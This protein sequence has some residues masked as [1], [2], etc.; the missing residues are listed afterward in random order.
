MDEVTLL[1][2]P[3]FSLTSSRGRLLCLIAQI[4]MRNGE[5]CS[6]E[7]LPDGFIGQSL[8]YGLMYKTV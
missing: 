1:L 3:A 6:A 7:Q 5:F 8:V 4:S 2:K